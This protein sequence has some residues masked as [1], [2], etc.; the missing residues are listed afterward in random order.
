MWVVRG[1]AVGVDLDERSRRVGRVVLGKGRCWG[2][3]RVLKEGGRVIGFVT[4]WG[5]EIAIG[6]F[7][8]HG[9]MMMSHANGRNTKIYSRT[10]Y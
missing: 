2:G 4:L 5:S 3:K 8:L 7:K 1:G 10:M 6:R 9:T